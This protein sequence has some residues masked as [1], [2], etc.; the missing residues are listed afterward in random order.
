MGNTIEGNRK[1]GI[2]L[3]FCARAHI[4]DKG[5]SCQELSAILDICSFGEVIGGQDDKLFKESLETYSVFFDEEN[6][7]NQSQYEDDMPNYGDVLEN[8]IGFKEHIMENEA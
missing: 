6:N 1:T 5:D 7:M 4:G 2:K 3:G 8:A